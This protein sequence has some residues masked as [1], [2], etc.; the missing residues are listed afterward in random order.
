MKNERIFINSLNEE[1][2]LD[3]KDNQIC[4]YYKYD[5]I[6]KKWT[7]ES[8]NDLSSLEKEDCEVIISKSGWLTEIAKTPS[9]AL[10]MLGDFYNKK[11]EED[12]GKNTKEN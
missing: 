11:K 2:D 9:G 5:H 1:F 8:L 3:I 4:Y 7:M 10:Y 12:D 6:S